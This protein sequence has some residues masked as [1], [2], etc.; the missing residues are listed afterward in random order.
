MFG[1]DLINYQNS[2]FEQISNFK[3]I[4]LKHLACVL[5]T[6]SVTVISTYYRKSFSKV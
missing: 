2:K 6:S 5:Q 4:L 1:N 3:K